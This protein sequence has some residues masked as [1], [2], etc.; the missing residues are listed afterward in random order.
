MFKRD[1]WVKTSNG[2]YIMKK[3]LLEAGQQTKQTPEP[4]NTCE[5][6]K[7]SAKDAQKLHESEKPLANT[8]VENLRTLNS[9]KKP[10]V[11][12]QQKQLYKVHPL[13]CFHFHNENQNHKNTE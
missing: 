3:N 13:L 6:I 7:Q 8:K 1:P 2:L 12:Y 5:N 4:E 10:H 9:N 11:F